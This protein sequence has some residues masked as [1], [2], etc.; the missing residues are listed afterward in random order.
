MFG[1]K[2]KENEFSIVHCPTKNKSRGALKQGSQN[3]AVWCDEEHVKNGQRGK[4]T[5]TS[6]ENSDKLPTRPIERTGDDSTENYDKKIKLCR[7]T[8]VHIS[9]HIS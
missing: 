5:V 6:D 8:V 9:S 1:E 3:R 7:P 2:A 4:K